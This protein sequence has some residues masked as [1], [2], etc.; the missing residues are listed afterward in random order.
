MLLND[1]EFPSSTTYFDKHAELRAIAGSSSWFT[2]F[3]PVRFPC[4]E[5]FHQLLFLFLRQRLC[6][7]FTGPFAL[8]IASFLRSLKAMPFFII[9]N[10]YHP[11][12]RLI[13]QKG[14]I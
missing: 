5:H 14:E 8:Y 10:D 11:T 3:Q 4:I 1:K 2:V 13:F 12:I 9:L 7:F 6:F